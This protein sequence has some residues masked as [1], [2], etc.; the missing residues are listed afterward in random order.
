MPATTLRRATPADADTIAALVAE[1]YSPYIPRIGRKPGPML[2][3]YGQVVGDE[4]VFVAQQDERIVGV[5]VLRLEGRELLLV[6]VAVL[7]AC[8]GQGVGR[9]LMDAC[10]AQARAAGSEA[11]RLYT[12]ERMI[13]N[14]AIYQ[15]LG[16]CET[17][18]ATQD[19]FAR[20]FMR[21]VLG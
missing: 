13:E 5:L 4:L 3:D 11:I 16:Y 12:H 21:K 20:V 9:L 7:P 10:E 14:I 6:N 15:K 17:H 2:D 8:K 19:G 1:A 18:R